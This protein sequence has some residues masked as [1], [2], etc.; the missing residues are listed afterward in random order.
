MMA[1]ILGAGAGGAAAGGAAPP[2]AQG[3]TFLDN[4]QAKSTTQFG[5]EIDVTAESPGMTGV[6][7]SGRPGPTGTGGGGPGS[8]GG[9]P[10]WLDKIFGSEGAGKF[11]GPAAFG[12]D[13]F[14]MMN[15]P[16]QQAMQEAKAGSMAGHQRQQDIA[17][18]SPEYAA[19]AKQLWGG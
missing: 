7:G 18:Q 19:W 13:A 1:Q 12:M 15:A 16:Q 2:S 4:L 9:L 11:M 8:G 5:G 17:W 6:V 10:P 14:N 3:P